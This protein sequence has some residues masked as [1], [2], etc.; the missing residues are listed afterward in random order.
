MNDDREAEILETLGHLKH[1][2][3][4]VLITEL[5]TLR[6][7]RYRDR[8]EKE[9]NGEVRGKAQECRDLLHIFLDN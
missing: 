3:A 2:E 7:K 1:T 8:L 4:A 9:E 5:L 6:R